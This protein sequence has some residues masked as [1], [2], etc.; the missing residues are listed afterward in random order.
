MYVV[1]DDMTNSIHDRRLASL[2]AW[3]V[4]I[5]NM[6]SRP[7]L[8]LVLPVVAYTETKTIFIAL[9]IY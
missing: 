3:W 5:D 9:V 2:M 1:A 6:S 8:L 4:K 7:G